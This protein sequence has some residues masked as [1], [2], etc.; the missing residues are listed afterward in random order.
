LTDLRHI[1]ELLALDDVAFVEALYVSVLKRQP[2][3]EEAKFHLNQLRGGYGKADLIVDVAKNRG[4]SRSAD[5][6]PG[7][8]G[9]IGAWKRMRFLPW[10][11]RSRRRGIERQLNRLENGIGQLLQ[12]MTRIENDTKHRLTLIEERLQSATE[13]GGTTGA[14][15][16][17]PQESS[18]QS[19]SAADAPL[20]AESIAEDI[21]GLSRAARQ[22]FQK[23]SDEWE[24]AREQTSL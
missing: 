13:N 16:A 11:L 23:I 21:S 24:S 19:P 20:A 14:N 6:L 8:W 5:D 7:L 10:G 3:G 2:A 12:Q 22:I 15:P 18:E 9:F 1:D 17:R 4:A